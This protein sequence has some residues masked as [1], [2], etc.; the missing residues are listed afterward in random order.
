M[1]G[2]LHAVAYLNL[3][4]ASVIRLHG[5]LSPTAGADVVKGKISSLDKDRAYSPRVPTT[6]LVAV[7]RYCG[8]SCCC[9]R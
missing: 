4:R 3:Q 6:S 1:C 7:L 9:G 2:E 5:S 8:S